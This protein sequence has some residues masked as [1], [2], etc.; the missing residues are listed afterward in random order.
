MVGILLNNEQTRKPFCKCKAFWLC[1]V[2]VALIVAVLGVLRFGN[3]QWHKYVYMCRAYWWYSWPAE[4][5]EHSNRYL[6]VPDNFDG[7][8][9]T[10]NR[11]GSIRHEWN[12]KEGNKHGTC[13]WLYATGRKA[14]KKNYKDGFLHGTR[15]DWHPN[16]QKKSEGEYVKGQEEGTHTNWWP[17]G[18]LGARSN[19]KNGHVDG[20][21]ESWY[22]NGQ[23]W[24]EWNFKDN[25]RHGVSSI[26]DK[27]GKIISTE[28]YK[29]GKLL[30]REKPPLPSPIIGSIQPKSGTATGKTKVTITG[31]NFTPETS[32][33]VGGN[34]LRKLRF[35]SSTTM[36]GRIPPGEVGPVDVV[37]K[38]PEDRMDTLVQSFTYVKPLKFVLVSPPPGDTSYFRKSPITVSGKIIGGVPP[39]GVTITIR[40]AK[41]E[42]KH[43]MQINEREF[44]KEM[45]IDEGIVYVKVFVSDA[46]PT[47]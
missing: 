16:G 15:T 33:T 25:K 20:L 22:E 41:G 13:V 28:H 1:A 35:V 7:T 14:H 32:V 6:F 24:T 17:N 31:E 5:D 40:Q 47:D 2:P 36:Q 3:P 18:Q 34:P 39:F 21:S 26:Y 4:Q 19:H 11:D 9:K 45:E 30:R 12:Y 37:A 46:D 42:K 38:D 23:K 8:W 44:S 27:S 10:W 43:K 29:H